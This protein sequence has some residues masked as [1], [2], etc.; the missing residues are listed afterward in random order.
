ME[1]FQPA[2]PAESDSA[3]TVVIDT[4]AG[5]AVTEKV[6]AQMDTLASIYGKL[7]VIKGFRVQIYSGQ[8]H[9][10]AQEIAEN[11]KLLLEEELEMKIHPP[12]EII[13]DSPYFRVKIGNFLDKLD[14][15]PTLFIFEQHE[16][17]SDALLVPDKVDIHNLD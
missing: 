11:A 17:F 12:I 14:A 10:K 7:K 1:P 3:I 6:I 2:L 16:D 5:K 13:Y 15:Q 9:K 8:D 4:N